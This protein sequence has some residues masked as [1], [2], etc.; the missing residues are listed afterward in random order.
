MVSRKNACKA[1]GDLFIMGFN[2]F[3]LSDNT[4]TFITQ[5][6]IGGIILF[7]HNY[8]NPAQVAELSN[9]IQESR[10]DLPLWVSVDHEGG[11]VQRF[12]KGF[13]RIPEAGAIGAMDSPKLAFEI[14]EMMAEELRAVGVNLNFCPVTDIATNPKNPVIGSR[15]FG[16]SEELVSKISTA[17]VR[18][19]LVKGVQAC[20]KHFPGHGDTSTDSHFALPRVSTSLE[21]LQEREFKPFIKAF[22]AKCSMV[23]TSHILNSALDTKYPATLSK[24]TLQGL[25]RGKLRYQKL[26]I[27]DDM[28]M[29]AITD[30][31]GAEDAPR[32]ALEAG[33]D[34]LTYR[35][36]NAA[37]I[38]Y[39][40][41]IK[42]IEDGTL[43]PEIVLASQERIRTLKQDF[44]PPYIPAEISEVGRKIGTPEHLAIVQ[45]VEDKAAATRKV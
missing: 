45:K 17:M 28:E 21:V 1:L 23:M 29:K 39:E 19:H 8:E 6:G 11:K 36:E 20:I 35:S 10:T 31:Y 37:R 15:S 12:K 24:P 4:S 40:A 3:E 41:L 34:I 25:L 7:A 42:A 43:D 9:Q 33:C 2:G 22:K 13:T 14:A 18:G 38:A 30:H 44:L 27:S 32:L 5:A 26:I 16:A